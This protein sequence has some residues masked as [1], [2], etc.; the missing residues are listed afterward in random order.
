M[1]CSRLSLVTCFI[2]TCWRTHFGCSVK[3]GSWGCRGRSRVIIQEMAAGAWEGIK[4]GC[5]S[6]LSSELRSNAGTSV[7][8]LPTYPSRVQCCTPLLDMVTILCVHVHLLHQTE[9]SKSRAVFHWSLCPLCL[10]WCPLLGHLR[11]GE[12]WMSRCLTSS[13]GRVTCY[14]SGPNSTY[15]SG[16]LLAA[17]Y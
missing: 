10:Q 1:L 15:L 17:V 8:P 2:H 13:S 9:L 7:R 4:T 11:F 12:E 6:A 5:T 16:L 3:Q 14:Y